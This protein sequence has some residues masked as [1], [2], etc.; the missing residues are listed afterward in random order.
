[1]IHVPHFVNYV[2]TPVL[3]ALDLD[4]IAA[5]QLLLGTAL[6][7]SNLQYLHQ[8][9]TGPAVGV[10]QMEPRTH[11]DIWENY[12]SYKPDLA[13]KVRGLGPRHS[14]AE[15]SPVAADEMHGNMYYAAAMCRAHYL[16]VPA[17]LPA[18]GDL[19]GQAAYWKEHYNTF[20]GA[21]TEEE[22]IEN[23][24]SGTFKTRLWDE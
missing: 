13:K 7:E 1:M 15:M 16:R 12:L 9:G 22:Y 19:D 11:D 18:P 3:K 20:L 8:L 10:F 21:G 24:Q 17:A 5:R 2:I 6:Q 14:T 23:Y 4:S